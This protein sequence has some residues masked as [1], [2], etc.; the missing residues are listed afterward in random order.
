MG[1]VDYSEWKAEFLSCWG[2][3]NNSDSSS[4]ERLLQLIRSPSFQPGYCDCEFVEEDNLLLV[5]VEPSHMLPMIAFL[6]QKPNVIRIDYQSHYTLS[7]RDSSVVADVDSRRLREYTHQEVMS[8]RADVQPFYSHNI[9]GEN[10]IIGLSDT[11][12]DTHSCFFNDDAHPLRYDLSANDTLHRKV[13]LYY[14]FSNNREDGADG[15]GTHVAGTLVGEGVENSKYNGIAYKARVAFA[16]I[17]SGSG[18]DAQLKTP[19]KIVQLIEILLGCRWRIMRSHKAGA[20]IHS[21]SW[22][23][24]S[25]AYTSDTAAINQYMYELLKAVD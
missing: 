18:K 5:H 19:R 22:G 2:S 14:P 7:P 21:A 1:T 10:K 8:T 3:Y 16:D 11:G 9:R 12:I 4:M 25:S 20:Q 6:S 23:A 17:G 15:H 13:Y 24:F